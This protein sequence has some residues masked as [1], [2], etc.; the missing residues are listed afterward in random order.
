M[1]REL[2][3]ENLCSN[4][5]KARKR[6]SLKLKKAGSLEGMWEGLVKESF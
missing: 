1:V 3:V 4:I 2:N 5:A 6:K